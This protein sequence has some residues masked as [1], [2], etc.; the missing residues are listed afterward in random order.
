MTVTVAYEVRVQRG[1]QWRV[2]GIFDDEILALA[3]ARKVE[4]RVGRRPVVVIQE[5]YDAARN[6]LKSRSVYRSER[7]RLHEPAATE[8]RR[9]DDARFA[10]RSR[11]ALLAVTLIAAAGVI[12]ILHA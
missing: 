3:A 10:R 4:A 6:H 12:A 9:P 1:A 8:S 11:S 2:E 5:I 7:T